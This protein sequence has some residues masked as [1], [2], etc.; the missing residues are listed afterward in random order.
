MRLFPSTYI[1]LHQCS[2]AS[3]HVKD[4]EIL[5]IG[6][7]KCLQGLFNFLHGIES[8]SHQLIFIIKNIKSCTVL[9]LASVVCA[10]VLFPGF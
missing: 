9:G 5:E 7:N 8:K 3:V 6:N 2:F 1:R 10:A 4:V